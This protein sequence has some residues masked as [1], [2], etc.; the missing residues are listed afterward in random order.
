LIYVFL[1]I[2][3]KDFHWY[4]AVV[5]GINK[6]IHLLDSLGKTQENRWELV[7]MVNKILTLFKL[8][9]DCYFFHY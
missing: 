6:E 4:L 9:P 5:D 1:P 3:I 8:L 2:N 7:Y